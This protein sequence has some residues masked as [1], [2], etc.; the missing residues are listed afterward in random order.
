MDADEDHQRAQDIRELLHTLLRYSWLIV[1]VALLTGLAAWMYTRREPNLYRSIAVIE[2]LTHDQKVI[3]P[4]DDQDLK[5]PEAVET[6][7]QNFRNRSLMERVG[8]VLGL[9]TNEAFL[10]YK[11][12]QPVPAEQITN[13]LLAGSNVTLRP[14]TRLV[15]VSFEHHDPNVARLVANA[16]VNQFVA[17]GKEQRAKDRESQNT[18]LSKKYEELKNNLRLSEQKLQDYKNSLKSDSLESVS[19]E[20]RRNYVEEKLRGLNA[21]LTGA[22]GERLTLESDMDLVK[23]AG[24]DSKQLLQI[25]SIAQDPP[26]LAAQAQLS[27]AE[28]ELAALR[29]RYGP[30]WP[31][32]IEQGAQTDSARR[33]LADAARTAP[34]RLNSRLRAATVKETNLQTAVTDQEK[35][36]LGL[37]EK[38][39]PF[40]ALQREADSDRAL[41]DSVLQRLKESTLSLG[42]VQDGNFQVVEP[43]TSAVS[44]ANRRNYIILG[45][46][47]GG[48]LLT[49]GIVA[50]LHMLDSSIRTVDSAERLLGRHVLTAIPTLTDK[51][52]SGGIL[53]LMQQPNSVAAESFR[54]LR[55][56]LTAV[57]ARERRQ[58][59]LLTSAVPSEGKSFVAVNSA[60]AFAQQGH[61]TLLVEA[62]LRRPSLAGEMLGIKGKLLGIG[63]YMAGHPAPITLTPVPHLSLLASG[64]R[65]E[66]PAEFLSS[67]GFEELVTWMKSTFDR[68]VIDSA[69]VNVV[70]D[71]LNIVQYATTI[72]LV[73]RCGST[74]RK[75]VRR[76]I[77]LLQRAGVTPDGL[78]LNRTPKWN[79]IGYHYDYAGRSV[80]EPAVNHGTSEDGVLNLPPRPALPAETSAVAD[81]R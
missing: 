19:V 52:G 25:S 65:I 35:A 46:L 8:R 9:A 41:V 29:Q 50:G 39:I 4:K 60:I 27:R 72:C 15:D 61:K 70:S 2:I 49:A 67:S 22:K 26:V 5:D 80:Y 48:A 3:N 31:R 43:A 71:T 17:Q 21:D 56:S 59:V 54:T 57:G 18:L 20:D 30:K 40:R 47:L 66:R 38:L 37:E 69:P 68:I 44:L 1:L 53:A 62:D 73:V 51:R 11:S 75:V 81:H 14:R 58:V 12:P 64:S 78:V 23:R 34:G 7:I 55:S 32:L 28:A 45:A 77:E 6:I 24:D 42:E 76:A 16:L 33:S 13:L 79:G 36:L 10:G 74:P 63:D